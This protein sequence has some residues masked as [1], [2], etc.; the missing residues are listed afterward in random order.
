MGCMQCES[1]GVNCKGNQQECMNKCNAQKPEATNET[2]CMEKC[3]TNGCSEYDFSCT[4]KNQ[5]KCE[6]ECNMIKEPEAKSEE[7]QCIRYCV[8]S[9][10]KGTICKP[11]Q[12][13]E[14]GNDVCKMC[15]QQ[16]VHLY[17]GLV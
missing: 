1:I 6:K 11:S 5:E 15:A 14:Q 4:S 10:A 16:C 2:S 7:E 9:H 13:G 17:L 8:N 12:E 3:T